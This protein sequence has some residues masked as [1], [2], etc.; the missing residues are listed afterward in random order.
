MGVVIL[1][2]VSEGVRMKKEPGKMGMLWSEW[3][4]DGLFTLQW[5]FV[6]VLC[7]WGWA[8]SELC[9]QCQMGA[10][11]GVVEKCNKHIGSTVAVCAPCLSPSFFVA[12]CL[13]QCR[14]LP[15]ARWEK[16]YLMHV[17]SD[18]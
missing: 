8:V 9:W 7:A 13:W 4:M 12:S 17:T 18:T 3:V 10:A 14:V 16:G 15:S 5:V 6:D 1:K 2:L 11:A